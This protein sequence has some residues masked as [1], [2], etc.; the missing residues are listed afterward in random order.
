MVPTGDSFVEGSRVEVIASRTERSDAGCYLVNDAD[1]A[2]GLRNNHELAA[3]HYPNTERG[4]ADFGTMPRET[5]ASDP[6][7]PSWG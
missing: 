3:A 7:L 5:S 1:L 4:K 6:R 2:V